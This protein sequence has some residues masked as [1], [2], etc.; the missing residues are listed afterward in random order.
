[1]ALS[2]KLYRVVGKGKD[3]RYVAIDLERRGRRSKE[4]V[5]GPFYLRYGVKYESVGM[6]FK[7][8]VEAMQRRQATLDAVGSGVAVKQDGE[9]NRKRVTDE[10]KKFLAKKSLIKDPK[11]VKTYTERLGYFLDWCERNGIK[12]LDQLTQGD[13]LLPY[14][15]F[16]RQRKTTGDTL[17][18]PRYV[19]NIFQTCNTFLRANGILFAGEILGQLDYEEKEVKPYKP[20]ELKALFQA[21]DGEEKLWMSYFLNTGCREQ[22]VANAEYCDLF[23]DVNVVWVRS[24][25]H[26]GFKLKGKRWQNKGRKLPVPTALM[27]KLRDRMIAKAAKPSD[28]IFPNTIGG[29]EGH[30]LRKLQAIAK[31]AGVAE[32]ELHRFRKSYAD[33]LADEGLPVPTIMKRLGHCSLDV[34]LAYL[35]GREAEGEQEQNFANQSALALYA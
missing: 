34:T 31:R 17:F 33:T 25:P 9:P 19:Y 26:R 6:D 27:E 29:V 23:D 15:S 11:T 12:H 30:F 10:V 22:E 24:N 28:L 5:T 13:D 32:P 7:T 3:R 1:M 21:A 20:H 35:R 18:E 14:V 2:V 16:L 4:D 8:A